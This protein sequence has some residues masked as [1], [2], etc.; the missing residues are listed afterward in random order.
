MLFGLL[1]YIYNLKFCT[2][3]QIIDKPILW[4]NAIG[5]SILPTIISLETI[6]IAIKFIGSTKTAIL[7]ALEP[8][9]AI[10]I[11]VMFFNEHLTMKIVTGVLMIL[12]GVLMIIMQKKSAK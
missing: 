6:N 8:L 2:E 11:G 3:L 12:S 9:T 4:L 5:L 1:V 7:G 10:F